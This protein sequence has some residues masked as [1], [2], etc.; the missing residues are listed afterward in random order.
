M[1]SGDPRGSSGVGTRTASV[2]QGQTDSRGAVP[3]G[4]GLGTGVRSV[5]QRPGLGPQRGVQ[6]STLSNRDQV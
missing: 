1:W 3:S 6:G 5:Q 4:E 2:H